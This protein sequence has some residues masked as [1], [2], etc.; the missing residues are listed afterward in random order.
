MRRDQVEVLTQVS[1]SLPPPQSDALIAAPYGGTAG[2]ITSSALQVC[3]SAV[4]R[5]LL[6]AVAAPH[7]AFCC[8]LTQPQGGVA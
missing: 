8:M 1:L 5:P 3:L 4:L 7:D 2:G 6:H